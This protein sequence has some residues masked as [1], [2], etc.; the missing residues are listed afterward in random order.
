[1]SSQRLRK[2]RTCHFINSRALDVFRWSYHF[3]QGSVQD[4]LKV[5]ACYQNPDGGFAYG[6]E[7]DLRSEESNPMSTLVALR[8]LRE[9]ELPPL[10]VQMVDAILDYLDATLLDDYSWPAQVRIHNAASHAPWY[11]PVLDTEF[12]TWDPSLVLAAFILKT[13]EDKPE[14]YKKAVV[15]VNQ[16][17]DKIMA[18]G[19]KPLDHELSL[20]CEAGEILLD[21]RPDMLPPDFMTRLN[22]WIRE[23]IA[24]NLAEYDGSKYVVTPEFFLNSP[25]SPYYPAIKDIADAYGRF[26]ENSVTTEGYWKVPWPQ[27]VPLP[28]DVERE[29]R[30]VIIMAHMLYLQHFKP[31]N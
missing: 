6:L 11:E 1:M 19:F 25:K 18:L 30:G 13:G 28:A 26:L 5:L 22:D 31:T 23:R 17:L 12:Q 15:I 3:E 4:V 21:A 2:I 9:L 20:I 14:L 7:P 16:A 24:A 8:L 29:V 27:S 10:A